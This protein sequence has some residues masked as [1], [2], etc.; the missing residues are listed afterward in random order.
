MNHII[1]PITD[2]DISRLK[3]IHSRYFSKEFDFPDFFTNFLSSFVVT[4]NNDDIIVG[5]G[6][7]VITEAVIVTN[8]DFSPKKRREALLEIMRAS[9]FTSSLRGFNEL[10]AFV[11]DEK[12]LSHLTKIGFRKSKG[13]A[14]VIGV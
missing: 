10:H 2:E 11:Q 5:G 12:W 9:M 1:R 8:K 14:L 3:V 7:R 4:D 13:Q 6:V